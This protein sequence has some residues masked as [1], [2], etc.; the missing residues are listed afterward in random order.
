VIAGCP[1][2][3]TDLDDDGDAPDDVLH[4]YDTT[5]STLYASSRSPTGCSR[6]S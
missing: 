2:G 6:C 4:V 1:A 5:T 3:G